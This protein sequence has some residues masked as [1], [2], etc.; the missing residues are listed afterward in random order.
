MVGAACFTS[1]SMAVEEVETNMIS[2][3][4]EILMVK[5]FELLGE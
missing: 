5:F 3:L 2:D 4:E 1:V